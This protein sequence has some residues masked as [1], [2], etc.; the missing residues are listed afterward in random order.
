MNY[1][2]SMKGDVVGPIGNDNTDPSFKNENS[3]EF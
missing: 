1:Y 3:V 2:Y